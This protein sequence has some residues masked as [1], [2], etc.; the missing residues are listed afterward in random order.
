MGYVRK[1]VC[2][3]C[4]VSKNESNK[5]LGG[6]LR[7]LH[8]NG[9]PAQFEALVLREEDVVR[10]SERAREQARLW[11]GVPCLLKDMQAVL[12]QLGIHDNLAKV[13]AGEGTDSTFAKARGVQ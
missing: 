11:C 2:N 9:R 13:I 10:W 8:D 3:A 7:L 12:A 1:A 5:W 4:G 6:T